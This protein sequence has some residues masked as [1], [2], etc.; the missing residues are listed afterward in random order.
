LDAELARTLEPRTSTPAARLRAVEQLR[1]AGVP[2]GVM[3]APIIPGLNDIEI[4]AILQ[5]A[6]AAGALSA[7]SVL[8]RLPLTV[9][10][11]FL[12]WLSRNRP[13]AAERVLSRIASCRE[14]KL[15]D[16]QFGSRMRGSGP[17]ADQI[18]QTCRVFKKK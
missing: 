2:A 15:N 13:E 12:D 8:L 18:Q 16:S 11:V 9:R 7:S 1:A 10:P 17:L 14:G 4:P 5:A 3:L 6:A